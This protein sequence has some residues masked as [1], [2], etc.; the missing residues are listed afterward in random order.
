MIA[1]Y[2]CM[3]VDAFVFCPFSNSLFLDT[4]QLLVD[5]LQLTLKTCQF[6]LQP[7]DLFVI[8]GGLLKVMLKCPFSVL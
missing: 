5:L 1:K 6:D 4:E 2:L 8:G 7:F 3:L